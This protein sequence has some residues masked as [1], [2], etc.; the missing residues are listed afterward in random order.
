MAK[1]SIRPVF[2]KCEDDPLTVE[3]MQELKLLQSHISEK[4]T[5]RLDEMVSLPSS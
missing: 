3:D 2:L 5:S 4:F 1:G